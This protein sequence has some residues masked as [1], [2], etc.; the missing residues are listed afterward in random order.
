LLE[1][2]LSSFHKAS[3]LSAVTM[4]DGSVRPTDSVALCMSGL[5][6]EKMG[7]SDEAIRY[8]SQALKIKPN[9]ELAT[10]LLAKAQVE[11]DKGS[12]TR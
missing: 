4:T 5:V 12:Q 10:S 8:Y 3:T 2:A 7:R 1:E 6:L 11:P 9:D